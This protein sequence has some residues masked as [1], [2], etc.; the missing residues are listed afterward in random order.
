LSWR[1]GRRWFRHWQSTKEKLDQFVVPRHYLIATP[2]P[3]SGAPALA[4]AFIT[5]FLQTLRRQEPSPTDAQLLEDFRADRD[6]GA[7]EALVRRHGPMVLGVC[8]RILRNHH[9]AEDAFQAT[10]LVLACKA[11]S[12]RQRHTVAGWLYG[13]ACNVALNLRGRALRRRLKEKEAAAMPKCDPTSDGW[14]QLE[15]LLDD[16]V[17]ALPDKYRAAVV[18]CDLEGKSR[19][20]AA[21]QLGLPEG[22]VASRLAR[23]RQILSRCLARHGLALS[24]SAVAVTL[25]QSPVSACV[26]PELARS[27]ARMAPLVAA[28]QAGIVSARVAG[29]THGV[30]KAMFLTQLKIASAVVLVL[31]LLALGAAFYPSVASPQT[32][33]TGTTPAPQAAQTGGSSAKK[34]VD[35]T[36][37]QPAGEGEGDKSS[38]KAKTAEPTTITIPEVVVDEVDLKY[39]TISVTIVRSQ[40]TTGSQGG[41]SSSGTSSSS[42]GPPTKFVNLPVDKHVEIVVNNEVVPLGGLKPG[43]KA[44]LKLTVDQG[45]FVV[46]SVGTLKRDAS[47]LAMLEQKLKEA[48]RRLQDAQAIAN[49]ALSQ[50][51][52]VKNDLANAKDAGALQKAKLLEQDAAAAAQ[53]ALAEVDAVAALR[54][55]TLRLRDVI[56]RRDERIKKLEQE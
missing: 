47:D 13:V 35:A 16:A 24:A 55:E 44:D 2:E 36:S 6:E 30:L 40:T 8:R 56:R 42:G 34:P 12:V 21:R 25:S 37:R 20:E 43:M 7:F 51:E 48:E 27:L 32:G 49:E 52:K 14:R 9:D 41:G 45:R 1:A 17:R 33:G 39:K 22:T 38:Q 28:G 18:L 26:R 3:E 11:G 4:T 53:R 54:E 5:G 50:L 19:K 46:A 15:P 29:L 23:A 10:F 31:A